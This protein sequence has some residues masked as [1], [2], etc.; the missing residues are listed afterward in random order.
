MGSEGTGD[1]V[2]DRPANVEQI[3]KR[4]SEPFFDD[5]YH[6]LRWFRTG[7]VM[8]KQVNRAFISTTL[9]TLT[10]EI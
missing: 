3:V 4:A 2:L 9:N 1:N 7:D 5:H 8:L 10:I 6:I